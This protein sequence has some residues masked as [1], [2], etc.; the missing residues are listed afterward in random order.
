MGLQFW[1]GPDEQGLLTVDPRFTIPA[2]SGPNG[3][4]HL[5]VEENANWDEIEALMLKSYRHFALKRMLTALEDQL[6]LP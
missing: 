5:D 4:I 3:W 1:V 2:Y 6:F